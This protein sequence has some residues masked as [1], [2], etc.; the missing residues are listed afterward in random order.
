MPSNTTLNNPDADAIEITDR[1]GQKYATDHTT[2]TG[3][4]GGTRA[5][6][7]FNLAVKLHAKNYRTPADSDDVEALLNTE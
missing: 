5:K 7:L 3:C 6:A 1:N 4:Y 2:G